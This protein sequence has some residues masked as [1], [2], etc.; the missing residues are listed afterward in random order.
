MYL[1][2]ELIPFIDWIGLDSKGKKLSYCAVKLL[3]LFF[4]VSAKEEG[5]K[6]E[7]GEEERNRVVYGSGFYLELYLFG[8]INLIG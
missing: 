5:N 3:F 4:S 2:Q 6:I 8:L 1:L 7:P